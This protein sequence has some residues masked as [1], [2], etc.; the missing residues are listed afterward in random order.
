M[1]DTKTVRS[2]ERAFDILECFSF[3]QREL[4]LT[5]IARAVNLP[6]PTVHRLVG[7]LERRGW[8]KQ[9]E[10]T[11]LYSL[12]LHVLERGSVVLSGFTLREKAQQAMDALA[13]DTSGTVLLG[14]IDDGELV[15]VDRRDSRA[16]LRVVSSVGQVRPINYG[17]LGKLLLAY[18]PEEYVREALRA[19]P[20]VKR[21]RLAITCE[22]EFMA[23][24]ARIREA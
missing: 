20:L 7:V 5:E 3:Q 9:D 8:L 15:Y 19:Q 2:V 21:A 17:I 24:L 12:G 16:P 13:A 18:V 11:G 23:E 1:K 22:E 14:A 6:V 4:T 10:R